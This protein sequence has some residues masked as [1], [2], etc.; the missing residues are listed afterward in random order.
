MNMNFG[1]AEYWYDLYDFLLENTLHYYYYYYMRNEKSGY[2][3]Q[4]VL[5]MTGKLS[6]RWTA[7]KRCTNIEIL[8]YRKLVSL[9]SPEFRE[10]LLPRWL[11]RWRADALHTPK[12]SILNKETFIIII[13][14]IIIIYYCCY[15]YTPLIYVSRHLAL[16]KCV[17]ID[18][19]MEWLSSVLF[20]DV[21]KRSLISLVP[22]TL[23][24][25]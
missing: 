17:L 22:V 4:S 12:V 15:S 11:R 24:G 9:A 6:C 20:R 25:L 21:V 19:F 18:W 8:W 3:L 14:I 7:L 13:I 10:L 1:I 2:D 5:S 23:K 16:Y